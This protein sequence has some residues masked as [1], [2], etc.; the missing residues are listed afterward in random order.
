MDRFDKSK[1]WG[2]VKKAY[3]FQTVIILIFVAIIFSVVIP[4]VMPPARINNEVLDIKQLDRRDN[5]ADKMKQIVIRMILAGFD[6]HEISSI[7]AGDV[8][9]NHSLLYDVE[10]MSDKQIVEFYDIRIYELNSLRR[11][12]EKRKLCKAKLLEEK[13]NAEKK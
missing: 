4:R 5:K 8:F 12:A 7:G 13:I 1:A 11:W 9:M 6:D 2:E 10:S 3:I